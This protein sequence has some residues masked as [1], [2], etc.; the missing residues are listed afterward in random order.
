MTG[1]LIDRYLPRFDVTLIE[2]TVIDADVATTWAALADFDLMT[3][4]TPLL[5]AAMF[6]RDIPTRVAA[7][8]GRPRPS[9]AE[10]PE[11]KLGGDGPGLDGWLALGRTAEHEVAFGAVGRFWQPDIEWYDVSE[12]TPEQFA[13]FDEPGWGRIAANFSFRPYGESRTLASYEARTATAD[14]DSARRFARYW[15]LVRPFVGHIM[16]AALAGLQRD[17]ER[18]AVATARAA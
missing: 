8:S 10:P 1:M 18:R 11:L 16:R 4:S 6:V 3:I 9:A 14:V 2:H 12:M 5:Q 15:L 7:W 17:A 13:A